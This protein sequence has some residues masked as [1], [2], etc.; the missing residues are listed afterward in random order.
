MDH[1][2]VHISWLDAQQYCRWAGKELPTEAQWEYAARGARSGQTYPWG[3][4]R[5]P[6]GRW[7]TNIWQGEFPIEDTGEDGFRRTAPV[8]SFAANAYGLHD[9]SGNVWE[10]CQDY[11]QPEYYAESPTKN[12]PGPSSSFDPQEPGI[13]K[14]VQRGGSFMCSDQYCIGYRTTARMKGEEDTGAFHTGFR[15]VVNRAASAPQP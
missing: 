2:V 8:A 3:N 7:L 9:M 11:Y 6:D 14:R 12:P 1:P 10:W 15:C 13:I 5:N 4:E